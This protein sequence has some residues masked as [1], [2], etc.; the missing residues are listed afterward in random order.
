MSI[1][2][3]PFVYKDEP[4]ILYVDPARDLY[5]FL[6]D[7]GTP[8]RLTTENITPQDVARGELDATLEQYIDE[9]VGVCR[10]AGIVDD[11][12]QATLR[13]EETLRELGRIVDTQTAA[14]SPPSQQL[15]LTWSSHV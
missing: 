6:G 2:R 1:E 13:L 10:L 3:Y 5:M 9:W 4:G 8:Q 11:P 12:M 7:Q 15:T 14:M